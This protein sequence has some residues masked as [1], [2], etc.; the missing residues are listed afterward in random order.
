MTL[1]IAYARHHS[2]DLIRG[3]AVLAILVVNIWAFSM[4]FAAYT[5]PPVHG[6]LTGTNLLVWLFSYILFQEKFI[7]IFSILFGAGI[8]LFVEH[9]RNRGAAVTVLHYRRM[10]AL[11][12]IGLL[13]AYGLW[14]GDILTAYALIGMVLYWFLDCSNKTLL[15]LA[16]ALMTMSLLL[17][18]LLAVALPK[19]PAAEL[20]ELRNFW[21][22]SAEQLQ[23]EINNFRSGWLQQM[24]SRVPLS[25][26]MQEM[27]LSFYS[28]RLLGQ[29]LLGVYLYRIGFLT[30][31]WSTLRYLVVML[32]GL[33]IGGAMAYRGASGN[34]AAG[35][36]FEHALGY[37][38]LWNSI[39]SLL[40]AMGYMS[41]FVLWSRSAFA[42]PLRQLLQRA[43]RM[44]F[45]LYLASTVIC[46]T[47][48]YGHGFGWFGSLDRTALMGVVLAVWLVLL[49]F[50]QYWLARH[51]QGPLEQFWRYCT[52]GRQVQDRQ[53]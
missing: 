44:A 6:D 20:T 32:L 7:T 10:S 26:Q 45:T 53:N 14:S 1:P 37:G 49:A 30:G 11:L 41:L 3:I 25:Y 33:G 46:T 51:Q 2:L 15:W 38:Q 13:H 36:S 50:A 24:A 17:I 34:L 39:G 21:Q 12:L 5:N 16:A 47:L 19:M 43:G 31:A 29:M 4:P 22:P 42:A 48:F 18:L 9:A 23:T 8:A 52:Y 28:I 35:F 40:M 27:M